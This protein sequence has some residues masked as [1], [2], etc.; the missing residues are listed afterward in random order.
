MIVPDTE[1]ERVERSAT[2][3]WLDGPGAF[4]VRA[5]GRGAQGIR[6]ENRQDRHVGRGTFAGK[7]HRARI[8]ENGECVPCQGTACPATV[9]ADRIPQEDDDREAYR[10]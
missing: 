5:W 1:G 8:M 3:S 6:A 4:V 7:R 9:V 10:R 2:G